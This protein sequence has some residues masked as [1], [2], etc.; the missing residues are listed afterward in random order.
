MLPTKTPPTPPKNPYFDKMRAALKESLQASMDSE[1]YAATLGY[2]IKFD[3]SD[4]TALA[5]A[6]F[7]A[8]LAG[9]H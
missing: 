3:T 7:K 6:I 5:V 9:R 2:A 8:M 4:I 1:K